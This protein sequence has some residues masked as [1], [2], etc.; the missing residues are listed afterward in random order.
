VVGEEEIDMEEVKKLQPYCRCAL[1][2]SKW[3]NIFRWFG[4]IEYGCL[5]SWS[6]EFYNM[7]ILHKTREYYK[8][9][10]QD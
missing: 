1:C 4:K 3:Y 9:I 5:Y 7:R 8:S 6:E 10:K 2:T